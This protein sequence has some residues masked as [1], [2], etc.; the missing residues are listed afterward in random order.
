MLSRSRQAIGNPFVIAI[1]LATLAGPLPVAGQDF[2]VQCS[3]PE[4]T[5]EPSRFFRE[6]QIK[7]LEL[8]QSACLHF[9][10][11]A[12]G[13]S[14]AQLSDL[15]LRFAIDAQAVASAAFTE[16]PI[17]AVDV[18]F[19]HFIEQLAQST[20]RSLRLPEFIVETGDYDDEWL[21]FHFDDPVRSGSIASEN[22][23]ASCRPSFRAGCEVVLD[24][25]ALAIN[26]YKVSHES[27]TAAHALTRVNQMSDQWDRFLDTG[28]SQTLLDLSLTSIL[29]RGHFNR[30][31]LVGPPSR[32]WS[33][34][35]PDFGYEHADAAP[36]GQRDR[37]AVIVEW[38][39]VNW[40]GDTSPLKIPFGVSLASVYAD[41]PATTSVGHGLL[42]HFDNKYS[43]GWTTR[44]DNGSFFFSV[45]LLRLIDNKRERLMRYKRKLERD[46]R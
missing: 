32:Q 41:R 43:I 26:Y 8:N 28:R 10:R 11:R 2:A 9:D 15:Y 22:D 18:P 30:G 36:F 20:T 27:M 21:I 14:G 5:V 23:N 29:E 3:I 34:L 35:H 13:E 12:V 31:T 37:L 45:D 1:S 6:L 46:Y 44:D 7:A 38:I 24:D 25:L 16:L 4:E 42:F 39:G 17:N 19:G 33:L 40:W